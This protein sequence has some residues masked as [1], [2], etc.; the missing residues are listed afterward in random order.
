M[1]TK[2]V[3]DKLQKAYHSMLEHVEELV[4]K[5]KK[6]L[7]E[8]FVEAEEKLSEWRELSREEIEHISDEL[9]S[10]LSEFGETTHRVNQ[11]LKQTLSFDAA[12]LA[13]SI[14]NSLSKVADKTIVELSELNESLQEHMATDAASYSE[15]QQIWFNEVVQWQG[16]YEKALKQLDELRAGVRK[17]IRKTTTYSKSISKKQSNQEEHDLLAQIN[18]E[19]TSSIDDLYQKLLGDNND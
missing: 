6:P 17:Q 4:E 10:N 3:Q 15:Q 18:Q 12:Y 14:W 13:G 16:D 5:D 8:A 2:E 1:D 19:I 7:K 9:K 11:S